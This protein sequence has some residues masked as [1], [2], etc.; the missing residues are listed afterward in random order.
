M[1][2]A[3]L[4]LQILFTIKFSVLYLFVFLFQDIPRVLFGR[5]KK[6]AGQVVV[7]TG[8]GM[9][10]GK[11]V[12]KKFA[13][14][15][16]AKVCIL[17]INEKEGLRTMEE[18]TE[19][20][21]F[22]QFFRCDV[23]KANELEDVASRI[24]KDPAL[25]FVNIVVANAAI[26]KFGEATTLTYDD[27]KL[28]ND[29]NILGHI[30]TVKAFLPKMIEAKQGHIVSIGSIC[31]HFGDYTGTAYCAAKFACRGFMEALHCELLEK[32]L[33]QIA[34]TS[35]YPYFVKTNFISNFEEPYSTYWDVVPLEVATDEIVD[36]ILY[37]RLSHYIP[38]S[39]K[40]LCVY[41]KW[42][43]TKGT[44]PIGRK[45]FNITCKPKTG[46]VKQV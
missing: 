7:I 42:M 2:R 36:A 4:P 16:G 27:Y 40:L 25:G 32:G 43:T 8:S 24:Y 5:K 19:A 18:I 12:A 30:Y 34:V 29:V 1:G 20:G 41:M 35:I 11:E 37:E 13:L 10:M 17:D 33:E 45:V 26:L 22:A 38:G 31:S 21:G 3:S 46:E 28:N 15:Q 14:R 9:G 44:I 6:V 23:S 39:I